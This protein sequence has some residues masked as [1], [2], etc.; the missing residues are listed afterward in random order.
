MEWMDA[1]HDHW[2][3]SL[4]LILISDALHQKN[5]IRRLLFTIPS[6]ISQTERRKD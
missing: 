5:Q 1:E 6:K 3:L 2:M 4:L